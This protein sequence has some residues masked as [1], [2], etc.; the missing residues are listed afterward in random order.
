[1][2]SYDVGDLVRLSATF[3]VSDVATNP[4][5]TTFKIK[6]P[7]GTVTTY[8]YGTDA[9]LVR[10]STGHFHVD[11]SVTESGPHYWRMAGTGSAQAAEES[12]FF[13]RESRFS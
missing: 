1:M 8:V 10:D 12:A 2:N 13:V 3:E 7:S 4:T 6:V 11:W 5:A 9:Q